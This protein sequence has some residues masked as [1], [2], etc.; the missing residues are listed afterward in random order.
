MYPPAATITDFRWSASHITVA[1]LNAG[2]SYA[3]ENWPHQADQNRAKPWLPPSDEFSTYPRPARVV[4]M[5][6]GTRKADGPYTFD[7]GFAYF[8]EGQFWYVDQ[9]FGFSDTAWSSNCTVKIRNRVG[10]HQVFQGILW[11][12]VPDENFK[13][14]YFGVESIVF[15]FTDG[16]LIT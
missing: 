5:L 14:G 7:I 10:D 15:K 4:T 3:I 11:R 16:V 8:T 13:R 2:S 9:Y 12:P 6:N 1:A